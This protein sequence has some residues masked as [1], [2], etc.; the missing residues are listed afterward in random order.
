MSSTI[1]F[2][3]TILRI[4]GAHAGST[5]DLFVH[6]CQSGSSNCFEYGKN[7]RDGR[8][9]RDW[10]VFSFGTEKQVL[11]SGIRSAGYLEG[12][13]LKL[14]SAIKYSKPET[15]IRRVKRLLKEAK[16]TNALTPSYYAGQFILFR[17]RFREEAVD[18]VKTATPYDLSDSA[19]FSTFYER[20]KVDSGFEKSGFRYFEASGPEM[21]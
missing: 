20:F 21:R 4:P 19:S 3:E 2:H 1:I 15:Y 13:G 14:G 12:G 5:D 10:D 17:L 16:L 9:A 6:L 11:A 7:G 18:G 8:M